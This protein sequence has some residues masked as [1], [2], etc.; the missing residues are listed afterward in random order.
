MLK[1]LINTF[2]ETTRAKKVFIALVI[3][4]YVLG[5]V[6]SYPKLNSQTISKRYCIESVGPVTCQPDEDCDRECLK[7]E[8]RLE[9]RGREAFY[10]YGLLGAFIGGWLS[11]FVVTYILKE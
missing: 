4:G 7:Y 6:I 8:T 5:V 3:V 1:E 2:K 9:T 11:V 10:T